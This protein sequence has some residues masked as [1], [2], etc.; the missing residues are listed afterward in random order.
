MASSS[1]PK[2][3]PTAAANPQR[4]RGYLELFG[5]WA[6]VIAGVALVAVVGSGVRYALYGGVVAGMVAIARGAFRLSPPSDPALPPR[7]DVRRWIYGNLDLAF[8]LAYAL[9]I[10]KVI[11]N[12]LPSAAV[13]LWSLPVFTAVMGIGTLLGGKIGWWTA[14]AGGSALL[15]SVII[16]IMRI[17]ISA[18]FLAGV[19]GAFGKAAS[20]FAMVAVALIVEVVAL[21]PIVQIKFLMTRLGRRTYGV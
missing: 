9:V 14:I 6:L 18:A 8:A 13:H 2:G 19:Y 16:L 10:W 7:S 5:G 11:P 20:T 21:L 12:R 15:C 3:T 17:L 4:T 1:P